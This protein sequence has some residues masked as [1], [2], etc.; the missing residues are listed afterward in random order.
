MSWSIYVDPLFSLKQFLPFPPFIFCPWHLA[1]V[2]STEF[3][4]LNLSWLLNLCQYTKHVPD[5]VALLLT[6]AGRA[7][8]HHHHRLC[9]H[10]PLTWRMPVTFDLLLSEGQS[11]FLTD[12]QF[13]CILNCYGCVTLRVKA[14]STSLFIRMFD[15]LPLMCYMHLL[16]SAPHA[17]QLARPV[18]PLHWWQGDWCHR[19]KLLLAIPG[20]TSFTHGQQCSCRIRCASSSIG[21]CAI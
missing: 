4:P 16:A 14:L 6:Y 7:T 8:Y 13:G 5:I 20:S 12:R 11:I 1:S 19:S 17:Q 21:H 15:S 10:L 18:S 3:I 9:R 2:C